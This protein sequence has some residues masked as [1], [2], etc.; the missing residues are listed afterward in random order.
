MAK[1]IIFCA[2]GTWNDP[3][4]QT[5]VYKLFKALNFTAEQCPIYDDGVGTDGI[6]LLRL[7]GG[8]F[9]EGLDKKI[10]DGYTRIAHLYS[11]ADQLFLFGFSRGAYTARSLAGMIAACGLPTQ[12]VDDNQTAQAF[13]AYREHDLSI[14]PQKLAALKQRYVMDDAEITMV[15]VWDTV[16]ALG[17]P[18]IFGG[19]DPLR[20]GFLDTALHPDVKHAYHA[21][22][23]DERRR[24]FPAT[25]WSG[26]PAA[27]QEI[28]QV[29]FTGV[30]CD[31]GG[32]YPE[33]G[34]SDITLS[35]MMGKAKAL[36]VDFDPAVYL[37][38]ANLDAKHSLDQ[39]HES[40]NLKWAFP[41][42]RSVAGNACISNSAN[43]RLQHDS[44]YTPCNLKHNAGVLAPTYTVVSVVAEAGA[45]GQQASMAA[46]G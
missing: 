40:W 8:A 37:Q 34:L 27:G 13:E 35:W 14:R 45:G 3:A 23:I 19:I 43:I 46:S 7:L 15:G 10:K 6:T 16:G 39:K 20:Y 1:R 11:P 36:G 22:S 38:Y 9:G 21:I 4:S 26:P 32:G 30:H 17:I 5:N 28:E 33:T 24:E 12:N 42:P 18:A 2:D 25:L 41:N 31:V 29:Y 44:S